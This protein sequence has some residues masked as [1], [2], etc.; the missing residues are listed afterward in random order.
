[1]SKKRRQYSPEFKSKIAIV[2]VR[3][4]KTAVAWWLTSLSRAIK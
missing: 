3:G 1:M 2:A 4:D